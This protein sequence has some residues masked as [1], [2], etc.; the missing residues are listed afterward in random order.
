MDPSGRIHYSKDNFERVYLIGIKL[1]PGEAPDADFYALVLYN[2]VSRDDKNRPL[3]QGRH[4]VFFREPTFADRLLE[5]GDQA[6]RKYRPFSDS[7][8]YIYDLPAVLELLSNGVRDERAILA[9]FINELLDFV[10]ATGSEMPAVYRSALYAL[11]DRTTF[12]L[13]YGSLFADAP[14][15]RIDTRDAL[16]WSLGTILAHAVLH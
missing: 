9:D 3:T 1:W 13:E 5:L 15:K 11:A 10:Q 6:F 12:D 2:E 16:A 14:E 8:T 7:V 4:I